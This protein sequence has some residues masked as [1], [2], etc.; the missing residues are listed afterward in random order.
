MKIISLFLIITVIFTVSCNQ[1]G[2]KDQTAQPVE[3]KVDMTLKNK[4]VA[5]TYH[6]LKAENV[7]LILTEDFIG[8]GED[9]HTWD[10]ESHRVYLSNGRYKVDSIVRQFGEGEYVSTMFIRTMDYRGDTVAA[11]IM[12]VKRFEEGKIA[13]IW[14]YYDYK[15]EE[16]DKEE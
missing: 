2:T 13:E 11:P 15:E 10:R 5:T 3:G 1:A 6:D 8:K 7:D 16:E 12:H 4:E 14:E 9:G